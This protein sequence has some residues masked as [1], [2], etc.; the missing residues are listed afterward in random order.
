MR[1]REIIQGYLIRGL[2]LLQELSLWVLHNIN[3]LVESLE[4][5]LIENGS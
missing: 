3:F 2:E 5:R 4:S 1:L